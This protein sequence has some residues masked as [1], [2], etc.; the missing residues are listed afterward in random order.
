[1]FKSLQETRR[2][3]AADRSASRRQEIE[4]RHG[5]D[6][7]RIEKA[8]SNARSRMDTTSTAHDD[9][10]LHEKEEAVERAVSELKEKN[11]PLFRKPEPEWFQTV[12]TYIAPVTLLG[13]LSLTFLFCHWMRQSAFAL[14]EPL[15]ADLAELEALLE[16]HS[17]GLS[18]RARAN[19]EKFLQK[20]IERIS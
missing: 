12:L 13:S 17:Q 14:V 19:N 16:R 10:L 6:L 11:A 15:Q 1:Q 5:R 4:A 2:R 20:K 3:E 9:K 7:A 18:A 8:Y